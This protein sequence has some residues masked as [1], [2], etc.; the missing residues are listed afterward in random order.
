[1]ESKPV[2]MFLCSQNSARSQMAEG[3]LRD[4]AGERFEIHSAGLEPGGVHPLAIR[5]MAEID[6]DISHHESKAA[7]DFLGRLPVRHLAIVCGTAA[8]LCPSSWPGV[9]ERVVWPFDDPAAAEGSEEERLA[10]FRTVR[11]QIREQLGVWLE[12]KDR[13]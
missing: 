10:V 3:L 11:D 2:V 8:E 1:M 13:A 7:G 6:I 12:E 4:M 5:A 9:I